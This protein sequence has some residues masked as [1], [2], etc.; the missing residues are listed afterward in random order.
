MRA[1]VILGSLGSMVEMNFQPC[2]MNLLESFSFQVCFFNAQLANFQICILF[3]FF[4]NFQQ[5][6]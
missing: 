3:F 2:A 1:M 5:R 4:P 6:T